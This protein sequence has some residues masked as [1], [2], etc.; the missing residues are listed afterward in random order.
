MTK[1]ALEETVDAILRTQWTRRDGKDVPNDK[2]VALLQD[3]VDLDAAVL[4][5]DL[6][7]SSAMIQSETESFA[8]E[9]IKSYLGCATKIIHGNSGWM[10]SYDGD[11]VMGV[12]VTGWKNTNAIKAA[13][14]IN[15]SVRNIIVP[16]IL[17]FY[18]SSRPHFD[19][20]QAVGVDAS[21]V[22]AA[23]A[24]QRGAS[25]LVWIGRAATFAAHLSEIRDDYS[26]HISAG[27]YKNCHEDGRQGGEPRRDMWESSATTWQGQTHL[28]YR[29]NWIWTP[30]D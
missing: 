18:K 11:R 22:M 20:R 7:G 8:A 30:P 9:V 27:V 23:R 2:D 15:Y 19:L 26:T 25:D 29:S 28:I 16:K 13:L 17:A 10:T 5:A 1:K 3:G 14:Q 24:G 12:F 21:K 6:I 4:Y